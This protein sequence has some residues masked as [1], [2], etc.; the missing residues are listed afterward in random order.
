MMSDT[1]RSCHHACYHSHTYIL[2]LASLAI[3]PLHQKASKAEDAKMSDGGS[4]L[5]SPR[6]DDNITSYVNKED[7]A[8][9]SG[10]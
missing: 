8:G 7:V 10:S 5:D 2:L 1:R 9:S 6:D 4:E 3:Q